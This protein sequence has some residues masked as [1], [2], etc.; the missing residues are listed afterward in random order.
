MEWIA[1]VRERATN[2]ICGEMKYNMVTKPVEVILIKWVGTSHRFDKSLFWQDVNSIVSVNGQHISALSLSNLDLRS[3]PCATSW[4][5]N[6]PI[7]C[8]WIA[9][10][11]NKDKVAEVQVAQLSP[12]YVVLPGQQTQCPMPVFV[13]NMPVRQSPEIMTILFVSVSSFQLKLSDGIG[14]EAN[15]FKFLGL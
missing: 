1:I 2:S 11:M 7:R 6:K 15:I 3:C 10:A 4:K 13:L 8:L 12:S 9:I 5:H 14:E